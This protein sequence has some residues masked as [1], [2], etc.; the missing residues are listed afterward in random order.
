[1]SPE[2]AH[3]EAHAGSCQGIGMKVL[4]RMNGPDIKLSYDASNSI[5][6]RFLI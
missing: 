3:R 4:S 2:N 6:S 1:M 5:L